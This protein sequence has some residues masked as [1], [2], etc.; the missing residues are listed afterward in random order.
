MRKFFAIIETLVEIASRGPEGWTKAPKVSDQAAAKHRAQSEEAI[1][2]IFPVKKLSHSGVRTKEIID[3]KLSVYEFF[4]LRKPIFYLGPDC[5]ANPVTPENTYNFRYVKRDYA[6]VLS[7]N[8]GQYEFPNPFTM[9]FRGIGE[10]YNMVMLKLMFIFLFLLVLCVYQGLKIAALYISQWDK[11]KSTLKSEHR[12][13]GMWEVWGCAYLDYNKKETISNISPE[14][15]HTSL[16]V[17]NY[18]WALMAWASNVRKPSGVVGVSTK[19]VNF[20]IKVDIFFSSASFWVYYSKLEFVWTFL[21]CIVLFFISLPSFT[22]A[23]ALDEAH[24]P[25]T[26]IK[27]LGSQWFWVYESS[28]HE[29]EIV[30]YSNIVYGQDLSDNALRAIEADCVVTLV[31]NKFNRIL[32]TSADVI[33]CWAVPNLGIKIDA[34]PGRINTVSV[35]PTKCG[36]YYGQC[37]EI[38]GVNHGFMPIVVE[39]V[40]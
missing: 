24:K 39:V 13:M 19:I 14:P 21:P 26:W 2:V 12:L 33:H 31:N 8:S 9:E 18:W 7:F 17:E 30:L 4:G 35:M 1:E 36:V 40:V 15:K 11:V 5:Y 3:A 6:E 38:C 10:L 32:V 23:L 27:V 34:C 20:Y 22:L 28:N 29:T 37:S 25:A 16:Y